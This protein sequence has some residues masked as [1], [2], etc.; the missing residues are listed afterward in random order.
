VQPDLIRC[1]RGVGCCVHRGHTMYRIHDGVT[2]RPRRKE[3]GSLVP[4]RRPAETRGSDKGCGRAPSWHG[5]FCRGTRVLLVPSSSVP[6]LGLAVVQQPRSMGQRLGRAADMGLV[7]QRAPHGPVTGCA[8][9]H[10]LRGTSQISLQGCRLATY[11]T[12][13]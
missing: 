9:A 6:A 10:G 12:G 3:L 13:L 11:K 2:D 4:L 8:G 1:R 7:G 5:C